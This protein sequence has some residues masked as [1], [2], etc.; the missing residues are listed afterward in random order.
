MLSKAKIEMSLADWQELQQAKEALERRVTE[1]KKTIDDVRL[2]EAGSEAHAF[3]DAF[4]QAMEIVRFA[5]ANLDPLSTRG[6]PVESLRAVCDHIEAR[7][8][9]DES[10]REAVGDLRLFCLEIEKFETARREGRAH[11]LAAPAPVLPI[12]VGSEPSA[13]LEFSGG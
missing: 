8:G 5:I 4:S 12:R 10:A 3:R 6:W 2:G 11:E 9:V 7:P 13:D 1:L